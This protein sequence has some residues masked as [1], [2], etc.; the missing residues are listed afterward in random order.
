[1]FV[2]HFEMPL[3]G[4]QGAHGISLALVETGME[5]FTKGTN[6]KKIGM[7]AQVT[8]RCVNKL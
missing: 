4:P 2:H 1:M 6:L 5:G 7:K 8:M 3:C